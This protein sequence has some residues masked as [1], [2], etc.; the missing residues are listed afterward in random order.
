M[1]AYS[2]LPEIA[3]RLAAV[4]TP[5]RLV[6]FTQTF[7]CDTCY[8]ARQTADQIASLSE[9]ISVEEHNLVLDKDEV[10]EYQIDRV[11]AIAVVSEEDVGIRYYGVPTGF[12]VESLVSAIEIVAGLAPAVSAATQSALDKLDQDLRIC[13]FVTPT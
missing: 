7:G 3:A 10:V 4:V 6:V 8:E 5:V 12:E 11:P 9:R 2:A 13:V 1:D